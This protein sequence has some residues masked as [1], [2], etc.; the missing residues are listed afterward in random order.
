MVQIEAMLCGTPVVAT[1]LYGVRTI[2][3]TTGMGVVVKRNNAEELAKGILKV[4]DRPEDY[5]KPQSVILNHYG[6][7][8][9][10][11]VY[12]KA[13]DKLMRCQEYEKI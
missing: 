7:K 4:I 9:C 1:D 5:I 2:V 12:E 13:F 3:K 8:K 6:T 10:L 11:E